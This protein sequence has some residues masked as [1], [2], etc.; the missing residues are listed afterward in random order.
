V[1]AKFHI[2]GLEIAST[3]CAALFDFGNSDSVLRKAL[4]TDDSQLQ[5]KLDNW[6]NSDGP[7]GNAAEE[8]AK[9]K[10]EQH[11]TY[12]RTL[13]NSTEPGSNTRTLP[14]NT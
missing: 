4:T 11:Y 13:W 14:V 3:L 1:A 2:Q 9:I 10:G 5:V 12:L 7:T 6:R 8:E